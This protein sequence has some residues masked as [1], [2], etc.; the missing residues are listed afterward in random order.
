MYF[1]DTVKLKIV[2]EI[3]KA[4]K[5][6]AQ[7]KFADLVFPPT[8]NM[9]D[10]S[11]PCFALAKALG[12]SPVEVAKKLE[13]H[14][15]SKVCSVAATGPYLNFTLNKTVLS[16]K[17]L[18]EVNKQG[19]K[20][21]QQKIGAKK[22]VLVEFANQ[23]THKEVHIGHV[24]N[25]SYG[26]S[27]C[28]LLKANGYKSLPFSYINDFGINT[29]RVV[30]GLDKLNND[31][32]FFGDKSHFAKASRDMGEF[33]GKLY[34]EATKKMEELGDEAKKE[35]GDYMKAIESRQGA[36]YYNWMKTREWSIKGFAKIY[37]ELGI[38]FKNIWYESEYIDEGLRLVSELKEKGIL[39][40]S[41]GALIA[42]LEQYNLG[43]QVYLRADGTALYPVADLA[44]AQAKVKQFG[45]DESI[46]VVDVRQA[47]HFKQLF[48]VM[49]L[50]GYGQKMV[51]LGY[52]FV[53]LP[54]GAMSSRSGNVVTYE[55]LKKAVLKTAIASTKEKHADWDKKKIEKV[56]KQIAV[57]AMKFEMIKVG[58][59]KAIT[60]DIEK[61]LRF[62]GFT[63]A[64]LQYTGARINSIL[65]KSVASVIP[66]VNEE[67][68]K[69][70]MVESK[71]FLTTFEMTENIGALL[72]EPKEHDLVMKLAKFPISVLEAGD[73]YE[74][75]EIAK[76]LFE[77]AQMFNDYYHSVPVLKAEKA[78]MEARL[79]LLSAVKQV[80]GNGLQLLGIE[81]IE[82][83]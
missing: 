35:V 10:I 24:R 6:G 7:I 83:M 77:L 39:K 20:F 38:K 58:R 71:G 22:K 18:E 9:G 46:I 66:S 14:M 73:K 32:K 30:W 48:K 31:P 50:L 70:D 76:Y 60:F 3:N 12:K 47:L 42:D 23:N 72:S 53:T 75:S 17:V 27:V 45:I 15:K 52:D 80:L 65:R 44:L 67:S 2:K 41:Q 37:R 49:E 54:S 79:I 21:G 36:T 74:P 82:E 40:E 51:H 28:R 81:F 29:A 34:A 26:D 78:A 64:Y 55:T 8:A 25:F 57:G 16:G 69:D 56:A 68:L 33:L 62:D 11:L 19:E 61:S 59:E 63:A 1:L 13:S 5:G 43:V 4:L